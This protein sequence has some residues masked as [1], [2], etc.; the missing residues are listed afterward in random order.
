MQ[1]LPAEI[2]DQIET[3][4]TPNSQAPEQYERPIAPI[5]TSTEPVVTELPDDVKRQLK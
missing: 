3:P 1:M 4:K 5:T 2:A